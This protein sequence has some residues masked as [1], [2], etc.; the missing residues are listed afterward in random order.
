MPKQV[1]P[2]F[3]VGAI[4]HPHPNLNGCLTEPPLKLFRA[5]V[6]DDIALFHIDV[7]TFPCLNIDAD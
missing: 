5:W 4:T 3:Y 2:L 6:S 1:H 7:I